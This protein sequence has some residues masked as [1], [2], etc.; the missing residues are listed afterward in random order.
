MKSD[1]FI[2]N[3]RALHADMLA[4]LKEGRAEVLYDSENTLLLRETNCKVCL[5][6]SRTP[7][8]AEPLLRRLFAQ[9]ETVV[10]HGSGLIPI[11]EQIGFTIDPPC[12]QVLYEGGVLPA[13]GELTVRHP[14]GADFPTVEANYSLTG[15]AELRR[16]FDKPDFLGGYLDGKM[17]CFCGLHCEGSMGLLTVLPDYRRRGFARQIYSTLINAQLRKG[18]LPYAQVYTDNENSLNLQ[19][20]LGFTFSSDTIQWSWNPKGED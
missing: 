4:A 14:D 20:Q 16:D 19:R 5:L 1:A 8:E 6:T 11:A 13:N 15:G 7:A 10:L 12:R 2:N 17:V 9:D 18:R 3:E